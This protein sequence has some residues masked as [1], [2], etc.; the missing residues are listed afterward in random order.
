MWWHEVIGTIASLFIVFAFV[1]KGERRIRIVDSI[2][3]I[4][5]IIY[6]LLIHSFSV[7]F[8]NAITM[9]INIYYL[10]HDRDK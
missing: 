6:G 1:C 9:S 4:I 3:A 8:L 7:A 5:F 2:G 10:I